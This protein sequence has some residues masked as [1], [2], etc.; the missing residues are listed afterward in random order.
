[1][2]CADN[3]DWMAL[4]VGRLDRPVP[5]SRAVRVEGTVCST[6][7]QTKAGIQEQ[8]E[9]QISCVKLTYFFSSG[10]IVG[11]GSSPNAS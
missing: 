1:M 4:F 7:E 3:L 6:L 5:S 11:A 8:V 2:A 10:S 9:E